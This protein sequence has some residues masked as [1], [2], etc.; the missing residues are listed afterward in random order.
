M[1]Q[2][3]RSQPGWHAALGNLTTL[4]YV[5]A[6]FTGDP[7][8]PPAAAFQEAY[9]W[10]LL[11]HGRIDPEWGDVNRLLRGDLNL[12]VSGGPDLLRAIYPAEISDDGQLKANAGDT[13]IALVEWRP[14]GQQTAQSV[15]QYGAATMHPGS[16]HYSDQAPLFATEAWRTVSF[17][18]ADI[19]ARSQRTYRIGAI[20]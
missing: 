19:E 16:P 18:R 9:D 1:P 13:W 7:G 17:D 3:H 15:H 14:D 11:H 10:L 6:E 2:R 5:T 8:P 12:P 4:R 20:D